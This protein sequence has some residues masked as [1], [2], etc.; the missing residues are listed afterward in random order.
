MKQV[1]LTKESIQ[2]LIPHSGGMCLLEN[3][4]A[5]S[6][7]EI[8]CQTRSHLLKENP[9]KVQGKLS[10]MHL[11]EYGAQ[12]I[13]IHGGLIE[14]NK[15]VEKKPRIGYIASVKSVV[16]GAFDPFTAELT[17]KAKVTIMDENMKRYCF[18]IYDAE[19]Q[20][21]CSGIVL[22]VHPNVEKMGIG[23]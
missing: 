2:E 14:K 10:N 22:I 23:L 12:A 5:Y 1:D 9:L 13:A 15:K 11:I 6:E 21:I 17:V 4:R 3:V 8:V 20:E 19:Q 7:E 18:S 16:W